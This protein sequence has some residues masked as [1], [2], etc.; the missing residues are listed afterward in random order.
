[1]DE[2]IAKVTGTY[3]GYFMAAAINGA[4]LPGIGATL[5]GAPPKP[6]WRGLTTAETKA[7]WNAAEKK[8]SVFA[9]MIGRKLK[10]R[11]SD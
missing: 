8:P 10:E 2:P 11:N 6:V 9:E 5:Y 4:E 1:V 7:L 3:D